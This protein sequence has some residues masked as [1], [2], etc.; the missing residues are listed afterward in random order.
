MVF[1]IKIHQDMMVFNIKIDQ[2]FAANKGFAPIP[3]KNDAFFKM[4]C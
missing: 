1:N 3:W 4:F 2:S